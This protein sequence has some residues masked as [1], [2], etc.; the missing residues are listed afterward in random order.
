MVLSSWEFL[1]R[2]SP[3]VVVLAVFFFASLLVTVSWACV[4]ILTIGKHSSTLAPELG[5]AYTL[6][7]DPAALNRWGYLYVQFRTQTYYYILPQLTYLLAKCLAIGT[8]QNHGTAQSVVVLVLDVFY[9][10]A[11]SILRPW[12]DR[13]TNIINIAIAATNALN[14]IMV[15]IFSGVTGAPAMVPGVFGVVFF[16]ANAVFALILMVLLGVATVIALC[17]K[18][19]EERYA[20][21]RGVGVLPLSSEAGLGEKRRDLDADPTR[22][23]GSVTRKALSAR[24]TRSGVSRNTSPSARGQGDWNVGAGYER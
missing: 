5:P 4:K 6:Y 21:G 1:R 22:A 13:R 2:D 10:I 15:F 17:S 18:D 9:L 11:V 3:A 14:S 7:S 12:L 16:I 20:C 23:T 8:A 24:S 19:P